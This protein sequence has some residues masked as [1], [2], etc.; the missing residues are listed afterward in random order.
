MIRRLL[1][2]ATFA[3]A[4]TACSDTSVQPTETSEIANPSFAA[5]GNS[6]PSASGAGHFEITDDLRTFSFH[7][8]TAKDG[9]VSGQAQ[10]NN[11]FLGVATHIVVNCL[12]VVGT[13]AYV[14]GVISKHS[15]PAFVGTG[16]RWKV[17]D[18]GEGANALPDRISLVTPGGPGGTPLNWC[19]SVS[20]TPTNAIAGNIQVKP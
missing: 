3:L 10:L 1:V 15:I 17:Q 7:A 8:N 4:V 16:A 13:T 20:P 2:A 19:L 14:S 12:R 6:G 9:S 11:R 18:N 5:G